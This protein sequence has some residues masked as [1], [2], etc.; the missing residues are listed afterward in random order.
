MAVL[1]IHVCITNHPK[2]V[3]S[4]NS[5]YFT[6]DRSVLS[7]TALHGLRNGHGCFLAYLPPLSSGS[8]LGLSKGSS[9][10][11]NN[12]ACF[13]EI[14]R[15]L[16]WGFVICVLKDQLLIPCP[17]GLRNIVPKIVTRRA[18]WLSSDRLEQ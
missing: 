3:A 15:N 8:Q 17:N 2:T 5:S 1:V 14:N 7:S 12:Q 16:L 18:I 13:D 11:Q 4:N 10:E 6:R 9:I